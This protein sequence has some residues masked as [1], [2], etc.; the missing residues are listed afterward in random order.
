MSYEFI[1][2]Y[3]LA[4]VAGNSRMELKEAEIANL[5]KLLE[6]TDDPLVKEMCEER[7][8]QHYSVKV[9]RYQREKEQEKRIL[10]RE[11][12]RKKRREAKIAER[13]AVKA[14]KAEEKHY[15][16]TNNKPYN[17][18]P[19]RAWFIFWVICTIVNVFSIKT[20]TTP[21][22]LL[23]SI[24]QCF[25]LY[26]PTDYQGGELAKKFAWFS[27]FAVMMVVSQIS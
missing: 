12:E 6:Q 23:S 18:N 3:N 4:T 26:L 15:C 19:H 8:A 20:Q 25:A 11:I 22:A 27:F 2:A 14:K 9:A 5:M 13:L 1:N 7:I 10:E 17:L 21:L 16:E 24:P